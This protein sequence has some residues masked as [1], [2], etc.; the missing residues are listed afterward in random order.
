MLDDKRNKILENVKKAIPSDLSSGGSPESDPD[1]DL[2]SKLEL[3]L[4]NKGSLG[5]K[6]DL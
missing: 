2:E 5:P 1:S 3:G 4:P 6:R